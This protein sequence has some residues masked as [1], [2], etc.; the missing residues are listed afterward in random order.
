MTIKWAEKF[1]IMDFLSN[2]GL[3]VNLIIF[4]RKKFNEVEEI[5]IWGQNYE[6]YMNWIR[7]TKAGRPVR[8]RLLTES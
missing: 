5:R 7:N 2:V 4:E 3:T 8:N 1:C 6:S